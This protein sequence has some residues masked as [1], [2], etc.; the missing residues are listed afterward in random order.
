[1]RDSKLILSRAVTLQLLHLLVKFQSVT[2]VLEKK[3]RILNGLMFY[4]PASVEQN[5][6]RSINNKR[7]AGRNSPFCPQ[8]LF[9][10]FYRFSATQ[11]SGF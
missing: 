2:S 5:T 3:R 4:Y 6:S 8:P 9:L 10:S 7:L 11:L 1:M